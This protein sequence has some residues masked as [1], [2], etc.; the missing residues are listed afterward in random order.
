L[1]EYTLTSN[2]SPFIDPNTET[3]K[4]TNISATQNIATDHN[5]ACAKKWILLKVNK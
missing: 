2:Y 3:L 5:D 4:N 1:K